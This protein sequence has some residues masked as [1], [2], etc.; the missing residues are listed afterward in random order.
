M[1]DDY[2]LVVSEKYNEDP[3][4]IVDDAATD[5]RI[6]YTRRYGPYGKLVSACRIPV[7]LLTL[8]NKYK[9]FPSN[10]NN[11]L[12]G[13]GKQATADRIAVLRQY[14]AIVGKRPSIKN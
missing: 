9:V 5:G 3:Q 2:P 4:S 1:T 8:I 6:E 10:T 14:I 7:N 12:Y 13:F 11:I